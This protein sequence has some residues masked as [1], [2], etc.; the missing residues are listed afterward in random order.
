MAIDV[1]PTRTASLSEHVAEEIRALLARRRT[2]QSQLARQLGVSEQWISV[3]LRGVQPIDLNDLAR[4]AEAL[5]VSVVA[6][7]P[8]SIR[9]GK[10][11]TLR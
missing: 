4:I 2:R 3:R 1:T 7:L 6:L 11:V 9:E 10:D 5:D 8:A